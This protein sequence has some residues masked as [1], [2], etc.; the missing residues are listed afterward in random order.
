MPALKNSGWYSLQSTRPYPLDD[1]ATGTAD[2]GTLLKNDILV[3][4]QLRFP[5][6]LGQYAY[7]GGVTV[8]PKLVSV[9]IMATESP[10]AASGFAPLGVIS[11]P[12]PVNRFVHYPLTPMSNGVGGFL[13]FGDLGELFIG[14]F[15]TPRQSLL[16]TRCAA[17]YAI[18]PVQTVRKQ[19]R[20]SGLT[21]IIDL[22]AGA[23][24][25]ISLEQRMLDGQNRDAIVLR[26]AQQVANRNVLQ[27]YLGP[28]DQRPESKNCD[29][30][31]VE[32]IN[33]LGADCNGN[34]KIHFLGMKSRVYTTCHPLPDVAGTTLDQSV[35]ID[36]V[37][38]PT[39]EPGHFTGHDHCGTLSLSSSLSEPGGPPL[40][41]RMETR[42]RQVP[43][44]FLESS[45]GSDESMLP[46][47][48]RFS[49]DEK[50]PLREI[51]GDFVM[52][53]T[54]N[55]TVLVAQSASQR[56]ITLL[57][58][59]QVDRNSDLR[60]ST[61]LSIGRTT[62]RAN[63]GLVL[64]YRRPWQ[65]GTG[66]DS[67][68]MAML[69]RHAG[70]LRLLYWSGAGFIEEHAVVVRDPIRFDDLYRIS[71]TIRL[72][73]NR[74]ALTV[75]AAGVTQ[76]RWAPVSFTTGLARY[77]PA[78]GQFGLGTDRSLARFHNLLFEGTE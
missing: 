42:F 63:G 68:F 23:D 70:K 36:E 29:K 44:P 53:T 58:S 3:D 75:Q 12:Q 78:D 5:R 27:V 72:L 34:F 30:E 76:P 57:D 49:A 21:G 66:F 45:M 25:D 73:G 18:P 33:G 54:G 43:E 38:L 17:P 47:D 56:N 52:E 32:T 2:D 28:C 19:G 1:L 55:D 50:N 16:L 69:D 51:I 22:V 9:V 35:G 6:T 26:L 14:R 10:D 20:G 8:T 46:L 64:N 62:S 24:I 61:V 4:C 74:A 7:V 60:I 40:M 13:V 67:Y 65:T 11:L 39:Q 59:R 15:S 71:A 77:L 48:I 37:C 31:G 41:A